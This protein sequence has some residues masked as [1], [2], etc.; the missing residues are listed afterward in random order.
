ML[1]SINKQKRRAS[2]A[3]HRATKK[4]TAAALLLAL[5]AGVSF[6]QSLPAAQANRTAQSESQADVATLLTLQRASRW[7]STA[8]QTLPSQNVKLRLLKV[9]CFKGKRAL[10]QS[11]PIYWKTS[12]HRPVHKAC[13]TCTYKSGTADTPVRRAHSQGDDHEL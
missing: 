3:V 1:K 10:T 9:R 4:A 6:A 7:R 8:I 2:L 11:L 12:A 13:T 5:T